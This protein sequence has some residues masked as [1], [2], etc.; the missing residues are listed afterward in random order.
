MLVDG[1]KGIRL[2]NGLYL[3]YPNLREHEDEETKK[4]EIVYDTKRGRAVIPTRIYGGKL[5]ENVCQALARIVI[6]EQMLKVA[7]RYRPVMTVH[8]AIAVL[9]PKDTADEAQAYVEKC[10][11]MR[12]AWGMDLPLNCEAGHGASYG[13]C[14]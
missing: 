9:A 7:R 1:A 13:E 11:K 12:P 8:D 3:H 6:G 4:R 14:K 2:P 5:I 10:M